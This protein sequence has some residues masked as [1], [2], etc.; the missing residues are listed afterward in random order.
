V[1]PYKLHPDIGS[2]NDHPKMY[3]T[4]TAAPKVPRYPA[5]SVLSR[6]G[7]AYG[8]VDMSCRSEKRVR[9][10]YCRENEC[11]VEVIR[12]SGIDGEQQ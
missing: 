5:P 12:P 6:D 10:K 1:T 7:M 4:Y 11:Q 8:V 3:S 2:F 9:E